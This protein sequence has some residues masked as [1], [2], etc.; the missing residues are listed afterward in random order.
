LVGVQA[1]TILYNA[2]LLMTF[3]NV[4]LAP[5]SANATKSN[6]SQFGWSSEAAGDGV[7]A[8]DN[9]DNTTTE[10]VDLCP[11]VRTLTVN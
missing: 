3:E 5:H 6:V 8:A 4:R 2:Q 7:A 10:F 9:D 1:P 11:W